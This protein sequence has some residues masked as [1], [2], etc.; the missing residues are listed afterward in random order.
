MGATHRTKPQTIYLTTMVRQTMLDLIASYQRLGDEYQDDM[1]DD[2]N[3]SRCWDN[4][5]EIERAMAAGEP[6][7][8]LEVACI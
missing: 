6:K 8:T 3:A 1:G 7:V 2:L 5:R 4:A